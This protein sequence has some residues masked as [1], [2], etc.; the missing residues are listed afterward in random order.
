MRTDRLTRR[1]RQRAHVIMRAL[2]DDTSDG[3][4]GESGG[5][6]PYITEAEDPYVTE[7]G[8]PYVTER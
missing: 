7:A 8:D 5:I 1:H 2:G 6:Q 4:G 3:G